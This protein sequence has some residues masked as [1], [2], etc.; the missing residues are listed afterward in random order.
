MGNVSKLRMPFNALL[1]APP[2]ASS[3]ST[4]NTT[5]LLGGQIQGYRR[6]TDD[7]FTENYI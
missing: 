3:I 5:S 1:L 6:L 2:S 7:N 4:E